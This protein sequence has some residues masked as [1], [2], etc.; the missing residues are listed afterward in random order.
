MTTIDHVA[1]TGVPEG[2]LAAWRAFL[3]AHAYVTELLGR[4]L[5]AE[6][7]L[8]LSWYDV[9]IHLREADDHRLRMQQ[10]AD[11]VLLS[12]SGLTRLIDRMEHAGLV[13]REAC[14][15]DRRGTFAELTGKGLTALR[16]SAPTHIRGIREH[17]TSLLTDEEALVIETV[18][19]RIAASSRSTLH[20]MA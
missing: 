13:R 20:G 4:E 9:L 6:Q 3:E 19:D 10:L 18:M 7:Q 2:Q 12:K 15:S 11:R 17:F 8:P 16:Q 14:P 1:T 5:R